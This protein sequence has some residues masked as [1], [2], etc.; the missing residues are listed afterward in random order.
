MIRMFQ[1]QTADH[2]KNYFKTALSKAD[3][4]IQDQELEGHFNGKLAKRLGLEGQVADTEIFNKLCDN[5]NPKDGGSL[6]PRTVENR[7]VGYDISFHAPKSIS[8]I[9]GLTDDQKYLKAFEQSVYET[10]LEIESDMQTRVRTQGQYDDRSAQELI[11][12]D[13]TH[14]TARPTKNA[15]ADCHV[16]SHIFTWNCVYDEVEDKIKAGQ[17]HNI[18]R[19]MPYYQARFQK[20]LADKFSEMGYG[21]RKTRNGF[22]LAVI[23]QKAIDL[24][25]KRTNHIG[26]VAKEEGITAPRLLDKL[27][28]K[29]REKKQPDLKMADLK[30][31]WLKQIDEAGI[32]KTTPEE[33]KSTDLQHTAEKSVDFAV[34]GVF[35]RKSVRRDRQILA[36]AYKYAVDNKAIE[37]DEIDTILERDKRIFK[38]DVGS[39]RLCTTQLV[40]EQERKMINLAREGIGKVR[41]LNPTFDASRFTHLNDEQRLA[42]RHVM[43]STDRLTMIRGAAGTG[44]TTLFKTLVPEIE[45]TG[46]KAYL[47]APTAEASRDVLKREGFENADTV[48]KLLKDKKLQQKIYGQVIIVDEAGML[49][50]QDMASIQ[51]I[52]K[53]QKA[54]LVLSGDPRQHPAVLRGDAMR[55]CQEVGK[56]PVVSME[57]IYRQKNKEYR[58][59]VRAINDENVKTGFAI[60]DKMGVV[61]ECDPKETDTKL[62]EDYLSTREAKKSALVVTPTREQMKAINNKVRT[63]LREKRLIGKREKNFI[64]YD[65]HHLTEPQKKDSRF[66]EKGHIIQ[67]KQ[68]LPSSNGGIKKGSVLEIIDIEK[69]QV[70]IR[71]RQGKD[72]IL[73]THK[74]KDYDLYTKRKIS[75]SK[76][77]EIRII[78]KNGFDENG[79]RLEN[80]TSLIVTGFTKEGHIRTV[81]ESKSQKRDFLLNKEHGN[82]EHAY[83]I[84]SYSSQG[85]T[86]DKIIISQ[87]SAT[88]LASNQKQFYVSV[89][90]GRDEPAIYTDDKTELLTHISKSGDRQG[91][92]EL[93]KTQFL[94]VKELEIEKDKHQIQE[95][96]I[97]NDKEYEPE[98]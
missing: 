6:T 16:H 93:V 86:V 4:Y 66:Y 71:D 47:F 27:G 84:T 22:E 70:F 58:E 9:I 95:K 5:I 73:P 94:Q 30:D 97:L 38:I 18:K 15:V 20:R 43:T 39:Q 75:L 83:A 12:A 59:A 48:A 85:K 65:N 21:I 63:G 74:A 11:W 31:D 8:L 19:D 72:H 51:E 92:T 79:K 81:K 25:S 49:G 46:K 60:L 96:T 57:T 82:F 77:D 98:I 42:M 45:K 17:F 2:A 7:R 53:K 50:T 44:K 28:A 34:E 80:R 54:K 52:A 87:P 56:I 23:P 68:N 67:A 14:L 29:T 36:E 26:Q 10:M 76:G 41:P 37:M 61:K 88:F 13:F 78:N 24:F 64:I 91:A 33:K 1:C 35:T 40:H 69:S 89:S 32:D 3:Y 90:R 55:L 62:V